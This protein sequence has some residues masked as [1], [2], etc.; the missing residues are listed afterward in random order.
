LCLLVVVNVDALI[1]LVAPSDAPI[2]RHTSRAVWALDAVATVVGAAV[3]E[4]LLFRAFLTAALARSPL[5]YA[6]AAVVTSVLWT[7]LHYTYPLRDMT[8]L[9]AMGLFQ[10]WLLWRTGSIRGPILCHVCV[11][12]VAFFGGTTLETR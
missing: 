8:V 2:V 12:A 11:G 10:S 5:G 4:E 9:F 3:E 7:A 1:S 6:G